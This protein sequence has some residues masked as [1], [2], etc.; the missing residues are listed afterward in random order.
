MSLVGLASRVLVR[1]AFRRAP[2]SL[3]GG[4]V[5]ANRCSGQAFCSA[6]AQYRLT[7]CTAGTGTK[8]LAAEAIPAGKV[9]FREVGDLQDSPDMHSIQVDADRHMCIKTDTRYL[10]HSFSPNCY[11]S[12]DPKPPHAIEIIALRDIAPGDE[13]SFDYST[14][15]WDMAAPFVDVGT[16]TSCQ[17]FKHLPPEQKKALLERGVVPAHIL[18]L[19]VK[20]FLAKA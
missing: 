3:Q 19:W 18:R 7:E 8:L 16:G 13:L 14:T 11:A 2:P 6:P 4:L 5:R 12:V 17:G 9:V 1:H 15:E 20:E 10:A